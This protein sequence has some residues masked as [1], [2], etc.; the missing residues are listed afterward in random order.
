MLIK[1]KQKKK[2]KSTAG[3]SQLGLHV[4]PILKRP[5]GRA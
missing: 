2:R 1:D 3:P 4:W 5:H